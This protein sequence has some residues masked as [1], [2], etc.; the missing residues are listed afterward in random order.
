MPQT[1]KKAEITQDAPY[2]STWEYLEDAFSLITAR[3][4][5]KREANRLERAITRRAEATGEGLALVGSLQGLTNI[6]RTILLNLLE[7][8]IN[9][10][11]EGK[12]LAEIRGDLTEMRIGLGMIAEAL[13]EQGPLIRENW[14]QMGRGRT[15]LD[16]KYRVHPSVI[17][18]M[19]AKMEDKGENLQFQSHGEFM[20]AMASL[21][22][23]SVMWEEAEAVDL[24]ALDAMVCSPEDRTLRNPFHR[25]CDRA[26]LHG[27]ERRIL[28]IMSAYYIYKLEVWPSVEVLLILAGV[29]GEDLLEAGKWLLPDQ[30]LL[31]EKLLKIDTYNPPSNI[32]DILRASVFPTEK[33]LKSLKVSCIPPDTVSESGLLK[34]IQPDLTLKDLILPKKVKE[35]VRQILSAARYA[36][37]IYRTWDL[38]R[39]SYGTT[40]GVLLYGPPGTGKTALAGAIA[41]E[42]GSPLTMVSMSGLVDMWLGQT[43]KYIETIFEE[44]EKRKAVLLFDEA[45]AILSNRAMINTDYSR[46]WVNLILQKIERHKGVVILTTNFSIQL[47]PALERRLL[48]RLEM[49]APDETARRDIWTRLMGKSLPLADDVNILAL[50]RHPLTGGQIKNVIINAAHRAA[51]RTKGKGPVNREDLETALEGESNMAI[52]TTATRIGFRQ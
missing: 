35:A 52:G 18:R 50:A 34:T 4:E 41:R 31:R 44:A 20:Y 30:R 16:R 1:L 47:D 36:E 25:V 12:N 38:K 13:S 39:I 27:L 46:R 17:R 15:I 43:E 2:Q 51:E 8:R 14:I 11:Q 24:E 23:D 29:R 37:T 32:G 5:N 19:Q 21:I 6:E 28:G 33:L 10:N 42:L 9:G 3:K 40:V 48:H 49:P 45:D 26:R 7:H 22:P